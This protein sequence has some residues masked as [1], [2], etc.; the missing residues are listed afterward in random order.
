[1]ASASGAAQQALTWKPRSGRW[2]V[3]LMNANGSPGVESD[4][5][6]GAEL[7]W[8]LWAAI[9]VAIAGALLLALGVLAIAVGVR[10]ASRPTG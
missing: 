5:A 4:M 7:D 2:V 9:G 3:V 1:V 6:I 10:R 8:L